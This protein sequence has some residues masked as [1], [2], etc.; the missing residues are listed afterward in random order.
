MFANYIN[1]FINVDPIQVA[2]PDGSNPRIKTFK[3][4]HANQLEFGTKLNLFANK[5]FSTISFYNIEVMNRVTGDPENF[6][7]YL[8]GGKVRSKGF[9]IDLNANPVKGL[10]FIAGYSYNNIK[11]IEGDK[12]DFYSEPRRSPG[13]QGPQNL[14]NGWATYEFT[15]GK[16]KDF[17]IGFGGN[18]G[19]KYRVI[20]NSQTGEFDLPAYTVLNGSLF[21]NGARFRCSFNVN[22]LTNT[23]YYTGYW[24]IN[25]Q[26]PIN[27][28]GS[29]A[30]KF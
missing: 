22:N 28:A 14:I 20:D 19:S 10:S 12:N 26:K 6:Y 25:P 7:N 2:D 4:E 3:P 24:S 16:L 27:F 8:Q 15:Q 29:I 5:L 1:A 17:G 11:V 9:E 21:Y 30:F 23:E 13:G 18:Y